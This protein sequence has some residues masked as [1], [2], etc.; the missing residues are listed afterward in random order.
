MTDSFVVLGPE[1][2]FSALKVSPRAVAPGDSVFIKAKVQNTG[3]SPGRFNVDL[4][5]GGLAVKSFTGMLPAGASKVI[6]FE[7]L[8]TDPGTYSVTIG[9]ESDSFV[10]FSPI[11]DQDIPQNFEISAEAAEATDADGNNLEITE[12]T[13]DFTEN[14]DGEIEVVI[15]VALETG[16]ELVN[17]EDIVSGITLIDN[18]LTTPI[19]DSGGNVTMV[20][21]AE[22]EVTV[23]TG[24]S[25][26]AR[27]KK[28]TLRLNIAEQVVDLSNVDPLVGRGTVS[29][30]AGLNKLPEGASVVIT[31][32][33]TISAESYS[34]LQIIAQRENTG[35]VQVAFAVV[36]E[37]TNLENGVDVGAATIELSVSREWVEKYGGIPSVKI[38]RQADGGSVEFLS[39]EFISE[40]DEG[41][42]KFRAISPNGFSVFSV[43]AVN[44]LTDEIKYSGLTI[45]PSVVMPGEVVQVGLT[46]TNQG[47]GVG[48]QSIFL[49]I[50]GASEAVQSV[51]LEPGASTTVIF[52]TIPER[53]DSYTVDVAGLSGSFEVG[54]SLDIG[55]LNVTDLV[56]VPEEVEPG[57]SVT[58]TASATNGDS[59]RGKF[60]ISL[61]INNALMEIQPILLEA[62]ETKKVA[63]IYIPSSAGRY[64]V[65]V[66]GLFG[67]FS[68][69]RPP[70]PADIVISELILSPKEVQPG[71]TV[72]VTLIFI[73]DGELSGTID[74]V[75]TVNGEVDQEHKLE[76][77]RLSTSL[78]TFQVERSEPG[79]YGVEV[80][81]LSDFFR[82]VASAATDLVVTL[83]LD[84]NEIGTGETITA[85]V[86]V[87]NPN[88]A[89][90]TEILELM[91]DGIVWDSR[92]LTLEPG[93]SKNVNF[94]IA[95]ETGD[96]V[97]SVHGIS[98]TVRVSAESNSAMIVVAVVIFGV[99]IAAAGIW[100]L[101]RRS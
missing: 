20:I 68:A 74:V 9:G 69:Q 21:V 40:N 17:F 62:G 22:V 94:E 43:L 73:N 47:S 55:Y 51:T 27:L 93:E 89:T 91:V 75:I 15:P 13:V 98:Q 44:T 29:F 70:T 37:R 78:L 96:H 30:S 64:S 7:T 4:N 59:E 99:L 33:K 23:G 81:E 6:A 66:H 31:P 84:K 92:E 97:I 42:M 19:R 65:D 14:Q 63:F 77:D 58:I 34:E 12:G 46:A 1:F 8:Q 39:T 25:A 100:L 49:E 80:G 35:V 11:L 50:N 101:R 3:G 72:D 10:V 24:T 60:D 90:V 85:T 87:S 45:E 38:T 76:I 52:F 67:N 88:A 2:E 95:L 61:S 79:M 57:E 86:N 41:M 82:V 54:E 83:Q 48:T 71:E 32:K 18:I 53:T 56:I 28:D 16:S 36:V 26:V 5:V